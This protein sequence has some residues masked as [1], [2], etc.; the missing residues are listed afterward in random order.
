MN[1]HCIYDH[2]LFTRRNFQI[3]RFHCN[4]Y[5]LSILHAKATADEEIYGKIDE[6]GLDL[7]K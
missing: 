7:K 3:F 1:W 5:S 2:I 6:D 4:A